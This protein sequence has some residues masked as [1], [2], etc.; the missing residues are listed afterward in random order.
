MKAE[1]ALLPCFLVWDK[2]RGVGEPAGLPC[3]PLHTCNKGK[4]GFYESPGERGI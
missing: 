1:Q 2:M 3:L 4:R